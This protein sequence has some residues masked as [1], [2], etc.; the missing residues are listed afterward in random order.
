MLFNIVLYIV[1]QIKC[2]KQELHGPFYNVNVATVKNHT[3]YNKYQL[4]QTKRPQRKYHKR[5][6]PLRSYTVES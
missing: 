4:L 1:L 3:R 5:N 2:Y 6:K